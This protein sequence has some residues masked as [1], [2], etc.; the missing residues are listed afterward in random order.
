MNQWSMGQKYRGRVSQVQ[1][2]LYAWWKMKIASPI[3]RIDDLVKHVH[4]AR[5]EEAAHWANIGAQGQRKIVIDRCTNAETWKAV[6]GYWDGS[7]KRQWQKWMWRG[8]QRRNQGQMGDNQSNCG[9]FEGWYGY[10]SRSCWCVRT[11][12]DP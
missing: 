7:F 5:N 9:S 1:K 8:D 4:R 10:C 6:K 12:G 3:S 2:T 11:H